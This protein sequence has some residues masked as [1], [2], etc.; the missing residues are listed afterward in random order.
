MKKKIEVYPGFFVTVIRGVK[1]STGTCFLLE[2]TKING[3][4]I[5]I[6]HDMNFELEALNKRFEEYS[7][8][9]AKEFLN[10]AIQSLIDL[11]N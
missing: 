11:I 2:I 4:E 3:T 7:S 1:S 5:M 10:A 6:E 9:A 8:K